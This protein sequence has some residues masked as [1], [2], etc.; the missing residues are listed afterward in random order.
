MSELDKV[1]KLITEEMVDLNQRVEAVLGREDLEGRS[2]EDLL[3]LWKALWSLRDLK[4]DVRFCL[5]KL[6]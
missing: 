4:S 3:P 6:D 2:K 5:S 1:R